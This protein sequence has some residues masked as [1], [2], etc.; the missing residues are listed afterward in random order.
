MNTTHKK[1]ING[2]SNYIIESNGNVYSNI[3]GKLRKLTPSL[4]KKRGYIYVSV[5]QDGKRKNFQLH[6]LVATHFIENPE[7][8]RC[9][10]HK[11]GIK[12]D[13]HYS[14]LEWVTHGENIRH[15][16]DNKLMIPLSKNEGYNLKYSNEICKEV[17]NL[18]NSGMT[19]VKAGKVYNMPYSTV[20]HL[21][22]GSRRLIE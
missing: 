9:V 18:V 11:N 4:N 20:A 21:I 17:I 8:K 3:K 19:Y 2:F 13:N 1:S 15:A 5:Q 16:I 7:N 22:R 6:Q 14:N 12:I 10:N